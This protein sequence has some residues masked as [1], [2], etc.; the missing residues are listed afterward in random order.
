MKTC[1]VCLADK[2]YSDFYKHPKMADGY[3]GRCKE[4]H[5]EAIRKN[6]AS[7]IDYYREYDRDRGKNPARVKNA[8]E[9]TRAWRA[10]D[11]R[12]QAAHNAVARALRSGAI[13]KKN[14]ARCGSEKSMAHH[15]SYDRKLDVTWL[16]QPC[17]KQR[18]KEMAMAGIET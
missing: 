16:C 15:E 5:K 13:D 2:S 3:L 4:C 12:R 1:A 14:C 11:K 6:R 18:H 7:R 8:I 17:H 9:Q 10:T